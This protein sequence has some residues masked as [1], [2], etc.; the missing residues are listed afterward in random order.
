MCS[1]QDI[2]ADLAVVAAQTRFYASLACFV[3]RKKFIIIL[4]IHY[5]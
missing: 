1:Q 4:K 3:G 5:A 2:T